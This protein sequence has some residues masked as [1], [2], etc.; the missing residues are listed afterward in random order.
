MTGAAGNWERYF[1]DKE[2]HWYWYN[3]TTGESSWD[4][5]PEEH[6]R[7]EELADN[8]VLGADA[9]PPA[10]PAVPQE[11]A[12]P[13]TP[14]GLATTVTAPVPPV[15]E[16]TVGEL[17]RRVEREERAE[18]E[19]ELEEGDG[20]LESSRSQARYEEVLRRTAPI[21]KWYRCCFF[22]H[23]CCCEAPVAVAEAICRALLYLVASLFL[24]VIGIMLYL[25]ESSSSQHDTPLWLYSL[26]QSKALVREALL[27]LAGALSL[28]IPC[29]SFFIY[30]DFQPE[31]DSW[32]LHPL[33]TVLGS[34]DPRRFLA[35]SFGQ[36]GE[37]ANVA[38][39][40]GQSMDQWK[41]AVL[42][43]PR[44][45]F[46]CEDAGDRSARHDYEAVHVD[47]HADNPTGAPTMP[48]PPSL[49]TST[50]P[51][52]HRPPSPTLPDLP[53]HSVPE[54]PEEA[55]RNP[56]HG[57]ASPLVSPIPRGPP[58]GLPLAGGN[59]ML[60]VEADAEGE[61]SSFMSAI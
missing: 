6:Q 45:I 5:T 58:E 19:D 57:M 14:R 28:L 42:H 61:E 17:R 56:M 16:D 38:V 12:T 34:V 10:S 53:S 44:R 35:F 37:A 31:A 26:R 18:D 13:W 1:D 40:G 51:H 2:K 23:A 32:E 15:H 11:A 36:G 8:G 55:H 24:L 4:V 52:M 25:A 41:G 33:P 21:F 48:L 7:W 49:T 43:P 59:E 29:C 54:K 20:M 9:G 3:H 39:A 22:C 47:E 50:P 60:E 46:G 27:L 30:R